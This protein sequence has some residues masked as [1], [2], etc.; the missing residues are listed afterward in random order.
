MKGLIRVKSRVRSWVGEGD[1]GSHHCGLS[2]DDTPGNFHTFSFSPNDAVTLQDEEVEAQQLAPGPNLAKGRT[3]SKAR[4]LM[5]E[6]EAGQEGARLADVAAGSP[7][8]STV[9]GR[10]L[11][12]RL[13]L[14]RS[15]GLDLCFPGP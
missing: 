3:K 2:A 14:F 12:V 6:L 1:R 15:S 5:P 8:S 4:D 9:G 7:A 13:G 10:D 11:E